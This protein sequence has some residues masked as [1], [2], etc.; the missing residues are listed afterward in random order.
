MFS[1][2]VVNVLNSQFAA[3]TE[4]TVFETDDADVLSFERVISLEGDIIA[5]MVPECKSVVFVEPPGAEAHVFL[6]LWHRG[7]VL[8]EDTNGVGLVHQTI[9]FG[10]D[11]YWLRLTTSL[12]NYEASDFISI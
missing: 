3:T 4:V 12:F 11:S 6:L 2:Q 5:I 9:H 10:T 7:G 1:S 8:T